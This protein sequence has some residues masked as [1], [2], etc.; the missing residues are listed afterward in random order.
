MVLVFWYV[1]KSPLS[2]GDNIFSRSNEM[3]KI[4]QV[5]GVLKTKLERSMHN[6]NCT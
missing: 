2:F 3:R 6:V 1:P 5:M 4:Y